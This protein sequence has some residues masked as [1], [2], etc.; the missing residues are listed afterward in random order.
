MRKFVLILPILLLSQM[1]WAQDLQFPVRH[2]YEKG[3]SYL[4]V[5]STIGQGGSFLPSGRFFN[6]GE[7]RISMGNFVADKLLLG[8]TYS[9]QNQ[10][11]ITPVNRLF[12][13]FNTSSLKAFGR[14]YF[15]GWAKINA[16]A[17]GGLG[18]GQEIYIQT[19]NGTTE[20]ITSGWASLSSFTGLGISIP[21]RKR[22]SVDVSSL[23]NYSYNFKA[24]PTAPAHRFHFQPLN[25][26]FNFHF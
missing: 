9:N 24:A 2:Q 5:G 8:I 15:T 20:Q 11:A 23:V 17:E 10:Y 14:Y 16:Y 18:A 4:G 22:I 7:F 6:S 13:G 1:I 3:R 12:A 26:G 21:I 19:E 25:V